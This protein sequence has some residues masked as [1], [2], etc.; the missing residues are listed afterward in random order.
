MAQRTIFVCT[1]GGIE[2]LQPGLPEAITPT[3][4]RTVAQQCI[5]DLVRKSFRYGGRQ[6]RDGI[7]KA[8]KAP[9]TRPR[10]SKRR[11]AGSPSSP[12]NGASATRLLFG[13][14]KRC[15]L[16]SCRSLLVV[17]ALMLS[18]PAFQDFLDLGRQSPGLLA[19]AFVSMILGS[20]AV[21]ALGLWPGSGRARNGGVLRAAA[22]A[23]H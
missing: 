20:A 11:R 18:I 13:S 17:A 5:V 15:G 19:I 12:G 3:W 23:V 9:S 2:D 1:D 21:L 4:D 10:P 8:P 14:G 22:E 7:V 6:H 16:S